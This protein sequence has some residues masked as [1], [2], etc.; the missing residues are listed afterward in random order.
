MIKRRSL[1]P[2]S[3]LSAHRRA[4]KANKHFTD[5]VEHWNLSHLHDSMLNV[6]NIAW[7]KRIWR[8]RGTYLLRIL[9][10]SRLVRE[11]LSVR[12]C[13]TEPVQICNL[14]SLSLFKP[15]NPNLQK[16]KLSVFDVDKSTVRWF[17]SYLWNRYINIS[18][19]W[20]F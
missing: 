3:G 16:F 15:F 14:A 7:F 18:I 6:T 13:V 2:Y 10:L 8:L 11:I 17:W 1:I 12:E 5:Q 20:I 19:R 4:G 9:D